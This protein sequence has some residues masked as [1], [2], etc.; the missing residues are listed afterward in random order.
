M[1]D[2]K[3]FNFNFILF[4][5]FFQNYL[6][7]H[8]QKSMNRWPQRIHVMLI[9]KI[10]NTFMCA[11][12]VNSQDVMDVNLDKHLMMFQNAANGLEKFLNGNSLHSFPFFFHLKFQNYQIIQMK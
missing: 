7:S 10:A 4:V 1:V 5:F 8:A 6:H 9:Q 11:S 2:K 3:S 12:M